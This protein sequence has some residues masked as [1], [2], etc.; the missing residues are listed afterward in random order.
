MF[1][2]KMIYDEVSVENATFL[3][4]DFKKK[5]SNKNNKNK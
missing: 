4:A 1:Y 3:L 2:C 5:N